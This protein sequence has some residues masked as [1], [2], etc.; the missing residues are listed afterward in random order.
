MPYPNNI[1]LTPRLRTDLYR[2]SYPMPGRT[3]RTARI[4]L[5]LNG[6]DR[7]P[8]F[9]AETDDDPAGIRDAL[10]DFLDEAVTQCTYSLANLRRVRPQWTEDEFKGAWRHMAKLSPWFRLT[11]HQPGRNRPWRAELLG[12]SSRVLIREDLGPD[13]K[14]EAMARTEAASLADRYLTSALQEYRTALAGL[15]RKNPFIGR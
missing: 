1:N 13:V 9:V 10:R 11:V 5:V 3:V 12:R 7:R 4:A 14:S 8:V 2:T 6:D 15:S